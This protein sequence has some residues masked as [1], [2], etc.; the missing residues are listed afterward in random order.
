MNTVLKLCFEELG[1]KEIP[2]QD[3]NARILNYASKSGLAGVYGK[4]SKSLLEG[5]MEG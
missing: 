5:L 3:D 4:K 1:V 2:G